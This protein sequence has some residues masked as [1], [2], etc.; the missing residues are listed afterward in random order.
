MNGS[1][2]ANVQVV[3]T[4][5][6]HHANIVQVIRFQ[7]NIG[8]SHRRHSQVRR[9]SNSDLISLLWSISVTRH[10]LNSSSL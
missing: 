2:N 9:K 1:A 3:V 7:L 10:V 4:V 5:D 8:E 6:E